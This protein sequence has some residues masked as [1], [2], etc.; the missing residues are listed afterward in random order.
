MRSFFVVVSIKQSDSIIGLVYLLATFF[1]RFRAKYKEFSS[2][3]FY[4]IS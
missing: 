4:R 1:S 2:Y 3:A